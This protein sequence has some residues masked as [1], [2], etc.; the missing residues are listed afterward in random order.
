[1]FLKNIQDGCNQIKTIEDN[2]NSTKSKYILDLIGYI[3]AMSKFFREIM[4]KNTT[5][6]KDNLKTQFNNLIHRI[7]NYELKLTQVV[8]T[9]KAYFCAILPFCS[10]YCGSLSLGPDV[11]RTCDFWKIMMNIF[12]LREFSIIL[13]L[14]QHE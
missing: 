4:D 2:D 8:K 11:S 1:M 7:N 6:I 3:K 13:N 5:D 10:G 12:L 14:Y 9:Q